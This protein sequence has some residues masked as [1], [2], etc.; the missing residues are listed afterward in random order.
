VERRSRKQSLGGEVEQK[1]VDVWYKRKGKQQNKVVLRA[2]S[3][4]DGASVAGGGV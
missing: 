3:G 1:P 2:L 4:C